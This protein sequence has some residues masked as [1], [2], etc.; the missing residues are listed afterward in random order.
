MLQE[1][2][3]QFKQILEENNSNILER[4]DEKIDE[5]ATVVKAGFDSMD[6]RINT[7]ENKIDSLERGHE[8]IKLKLDNVAYRF[9]IVELQRRVEILEKKIGLK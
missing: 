8:E 7:V 6:G 2:I 9:E 1:D 4:V 5:L 3:K